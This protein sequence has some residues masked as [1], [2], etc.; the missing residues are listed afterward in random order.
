MND[1]A[2]AQGVVEVVGGGAE[3]LKMGGG[4]VVGGGG[5]TQ[6][7]ALGGPSV[8]EETSNRVHESNQAVAPRNIVTDVTELVFHA[9]MSALNDVAL[10]NMPKKFVTEPVFHAEIFALKDV[11]S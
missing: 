3:V 10:S 6:V 4:V 1:R 9:V 8:E 7:H 11:A 2:S 5:Y